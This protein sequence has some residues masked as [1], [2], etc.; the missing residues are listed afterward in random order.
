MIFAMRM[1]QKLQIK[2]ETGATTAAVC[3]SECV[4]VYVSNLGFRGAATRHNHIISDA[5]MIFHVFHALNC[6]IHES[7]DTG[8][9]SGTFFLHTPGSNMIFHYQPPQACNAFYNP[10]VK[11]DHF[12]T[13]IN[14]KMIETPTCS[15]NR[16]LK[17]RLS[18]NFLNK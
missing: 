6:R 15:K 13:H 18:A 5:G 9:C 7:F 8:I 10:S 14:R 12:H 1:N 2:Y 11:F 3:V 4:C 17:P 16:Q